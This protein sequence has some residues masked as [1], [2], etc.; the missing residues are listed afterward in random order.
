MEDK[1][2]KEI[3]KYKTFYYRTSYCNKEMLKSLKVMHDTNEELYKNQEV[4][5]TSTTLGKEVKVDNSY[6]M[7]NIH[8]IHSDRTL[9]QQLILTRLISALEVSL[10]ENIIDVFMVN[11]KPFLTQNKFEITEAEILSTKN[12]EEIQSKIINNLCR[13]I[14][15]QGIK[16]IVSFYKKTFNI[17]LESFN[18]K[19]ENILYNFQYI[20][21]LH[22]MR[23]MIVHNLGKVDKK[24][25]EQYCYK[26]VNVKFTSREFDVIFDVLLSFAKYVNERIS[27]FKFPQAEEI[28]ENENVEYK[29]NIEIFDD[30]IL[31]IFQDSFTF[32]CKDQMCNFHRIKKSIKKTGNIVDLRIIGD[33]K[34]IGK[35]LSKIK[36]FEKKR[37]C[38]INQ[39]NAFRDF[40]ESTKKTD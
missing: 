1:L 7:M 15:S 36:C 38:N 23:H 12:I 4:Y 26:S 27:I 2:T 24:F 20:L 18:I 11:K 28:K 33:K 13:N 40:H 19:I 37:L 31:Y 25:K 30:E 21:M 29:M 10:V 35:Y 6:Q 8:I 16:S 39:L 3:T 22:D 17:D 34:V 14:Q 9:F 5:Y 32:K